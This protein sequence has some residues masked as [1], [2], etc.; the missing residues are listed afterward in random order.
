MSLATFTGFFT[1]YG[2]T[3][4]FFHALFEHKN[5]A[6]RAYY[7]ALYEKDPVAYDRAIKEQIRRYGR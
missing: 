4:V 3:G 7:D 1:L 5:R 6:Y 2:I